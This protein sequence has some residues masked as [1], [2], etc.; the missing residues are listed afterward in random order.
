METKK[1][2]ELIE[3]GYQ[4]PIGSILK[5]AWELFKGQARNY[6]IFGLLI[7]A[8][9]FVASGMIGGL[10]SLIIIGFEAGFFIFA[11]KQRL[12]KE[13]VLFNSFF[14]GFNHFV[15]LMIKLLIISAFEIGLFLIAFLIV[16]PWMHL[17]LGWEDA[18]IAQFTVTWY[19][20][21]IGI[22]LLI[23]GSSYIYM[24]YIFGIPLVVEGETKAWEA[25]ETSRKVVNREFLKILGLLI[26]V[27]IIYLFSAL[28]TL[29]FGLII[30]YPYKFCVLHV[31]YERIFDPIIE[32]KE[33]QIDQFGNP[34]V[35]QNLESHEYNN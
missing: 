1:H 28:L 23:V 3:K 2:L 11:R 25:M 20:P 16:F 9:T 29:G 12:N 32:K 24:I 7:A 6:I 31:A 14:E 8:V 33:D 4:V 5:E 19:V 35:D 15:P 34:V 30:L 22:L 27:E 26:V 18:W 13:E 10:A 21:A 17:H